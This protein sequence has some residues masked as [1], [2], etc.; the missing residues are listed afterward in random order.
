M[1]KNA[2]VRRKSLI[3]GDD[4]VTRNRLCTGLCTGKV[5]GEMQPESW[6]DRLACISTWAT[7]PSD[8][9][10]SS[11]SAC[12]APDSTR[13]KSPNRARCSDGPMELGSRRTVICIRLLALAY[14]AITQLRAEM[15]AL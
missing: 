14:P 7:W 3:D 11:S 1:V 6:I 4:S 15:P 8:N 12:C 9:G 5:Y 10:S 2:A 13:K